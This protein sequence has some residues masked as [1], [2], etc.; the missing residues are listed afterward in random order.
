MRL[1]LEFHCI[2]L[3]LGS[4]SIIWDYTMRWSVGEKNV[5]RYF[6]EAVNGK[7]EAATR[8]FEFVSMGEI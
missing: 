7:E 3:A 8:R 2:W 4:N 1:S 6:K 5:I